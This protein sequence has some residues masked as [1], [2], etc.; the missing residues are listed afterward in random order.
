[1]SSFR[2][3]I[4]H[5]LGMQLKV[6]L[7]CK[8]PFCLGMQLKYPVYKSCVHL[9]KFIVLSAVAAL[10]VSWSR[11]QN[12]KSCDGSEEERARSLLQKWRRRQSVI[13]S[14]R[15]EVRVENDEYEREQQRL[16]K[17]I[18]CMVVLRNGCIFAFCAVQKRTHI[19]KLFQRNAC[20]LC[21]PSHTFHTS[22]HMHDRPSQKHVPCLLT[23]PH[24]LVQRSW[25]CAR[26]TLR[27]R[28][29]S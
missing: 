21:L 28:T 18:K 7:V 12:G 6:W 2:T 29:P 9:H 3:A 19:L 26:H 10:A 23:N 27:I 24:V 13:Q 8:H 17:Q 1:M 5:A 4:C 11:H 22:V 16:A 15:R 14:Q 25:R 20:T